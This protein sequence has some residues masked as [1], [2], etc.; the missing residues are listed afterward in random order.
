[1]Q[2]GTVKDKNFCTILSDKYTSLR[3]VAAATE[4][5]RGESRGEEEED[6]GK[7]EGGRQAKRRG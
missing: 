2:V 5:R 6:W 1:M 4:K 3:N 7:R